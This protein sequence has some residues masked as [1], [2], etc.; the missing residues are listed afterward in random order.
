MAINIEN[1]KTQT[2][3]SPHSYTHM[4]DLFKVA[5]VQK[6]RRM[7]ERIFS[8]RGWAIHRSIRSCETLG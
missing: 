6:I 7:N 2:H 3:I 4:H 8:T 1:T 5:D